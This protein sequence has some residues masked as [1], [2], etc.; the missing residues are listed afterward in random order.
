VKH[1]ASLQPSS[2]LLSL[3]G[4]GPASVEMLRCVNIQSADALRQTDLYTLYAKIKAKYP[5]TSINL[6][7]AMMGAMDDVDWRVIAR[8]RRSEVLMQLDDRGLL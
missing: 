4:L 2:D 8:E 5:H 6:L 3:R 7:Y 1:G